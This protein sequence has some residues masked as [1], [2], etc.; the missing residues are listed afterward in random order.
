MAFILWHLLQYYQ[1]LV[2]LSSGSYSLNGRLHLLSAQGG[3]GGEDTGKSRGGY[4]KGLG[5][6]R[7]RGEKY[8]R[9][10]GVV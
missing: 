8:C 9:N 6:S 5:K 7:W 4:K 3:G 2:K 10:P 1:I